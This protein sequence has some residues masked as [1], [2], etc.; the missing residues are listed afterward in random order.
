MH[1]AQV[2]EEFIEILESTPEQQALRRDAELCGW[3]EEHD[4]DTWATGCGHVFQ[5]ID[6]T[7]SDNSFVYCCYCGRKIEETRYEARGGEG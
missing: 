7:P 1:A 4:G 6:G 2:I 5:F 3:D